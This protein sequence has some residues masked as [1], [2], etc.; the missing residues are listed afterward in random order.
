MH[1]AKETITVINRKF[2]ATTGLDDWTPTI[3][4]GASWYSKQV[5]SVTQTGLKTA[6]TA[7]VRIPVDADTG[8]KAYMPPKAYKA[9]TSVSGAYTLAEGDLVVRGS[10]TTTQG[11]VLTPATIAETYEDSFTITAVADNTRRPHGQHWKVVGA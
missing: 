7:A 11:Q 8:G 4:D 6:K 10:V 2:N 9:A 1:E 3:I 5:A